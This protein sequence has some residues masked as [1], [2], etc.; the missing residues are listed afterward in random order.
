M[1]K[2]DDKEF[3]QE[4]RT[5]L[6]RSI[7]HLDPAI[8]ERLHAMRRQAISPARVITS[9][10]DESLVVSIR[11]VLDSS[12]ITADIEA[13]LNQIRTQAVARLHTTATQS[14]ASLL[15]RA[16]E[17]FESLFAMHRLTMPTRMLATACIM[18]TVISLFYI[19]SRPA[20]LLSLEDEISLIASADDIEL[21]EN[22]DFYL[23]LAANGFP[24]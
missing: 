24:D 7:A 9:A 1:N 17:R 18:I 11:Q 22:L 3:L 12:A 19:S 20:G 8:N 6:D 5:R 2:L 16:R 14:D 23:W 4:I 10:N 15:A 21:Y 13:R